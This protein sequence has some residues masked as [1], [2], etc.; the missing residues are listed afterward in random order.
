[1]QRGGE[2]GNLVT[3]TASFIV[4][5]F[6]DVGHSNCCEVIPHCSFDVHFSNE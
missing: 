2:R 4:K 5:R 1:M 6:F 3:F